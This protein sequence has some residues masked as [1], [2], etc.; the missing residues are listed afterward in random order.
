MTELLANS[1]HNKSVLK[2]DGSEVGA[3][4]NLTM[5]VDSGELSHLVVEPRKRYLDQSVPF[6]TDENGRLLI[7]VSRVETI[8]DHIIIQ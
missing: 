3:I 8:K 1:L 7:P 6:E 2:A 4:Y 5:Y